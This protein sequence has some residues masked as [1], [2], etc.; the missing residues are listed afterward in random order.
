MYT[1]VSEFDFIDTFDA[2]RKNQFSYGALKALYSYYE[3]LEESI[4]EP[5][6]FD[7]IAICCEWAEYE[8]I[9]DVCRA[10][11]TAPE[12]A[13]FAGKEDY[14]EACFEWLG[15]NTQYIALDDGSVLV[16]EF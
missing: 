9:E 5:I 3:D 2:V 12:V 7:V 16:A 11:N 10:Y 4:G 15:D 13:A 8:S 6:E 1:H 14:E